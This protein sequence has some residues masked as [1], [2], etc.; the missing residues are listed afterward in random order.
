MRQLRFAR[1]ALPALLAFAALSAG[2]QTLASF[3]TVPG[4]AVDLS[5][6]NGRQPGANVNRLGGFF[7]DLSYDRFEDVFYGVADRGPGGGYISYDTRV[8][9]F[10]L[11]IDPLTGA[12]S[13][14]Q[15][16]GTI[17]FHLPAS[18]AVNGIAGPVSFNGIDPTL[19]PLNGNKQVLGRAH[20]PEGF[21]VA[22]S[23]HFYV[24]DEYGPS[25]YEFGADGTFLRAF[26]QPSNVLPYL[27][28]SI[29]FSA[30]DTVTAG[31][32]ANRGYEGLAISPDGKRLYAMLQDPLAQEGSAGV[33]CSHN[34]TQP[35]D[36]SRNLRLVEFD[37]ATGKSRAQ[38]IYQLESLSS[39][40]ER[41][42]GNTFPTYQ[43]GSSLGVSSMTMLDATHIAVDERDNRGLGVGDPLGT[44]PVS[45]KRIY[46]ID[47]AGAT[48]VSGLS[49]AGM[50]DP[51]PGIA[52]VAK[53]LYLDVAAA[54]AKAGHKVFEKME[55]IAI[56]PQLADGTYALIVGT[57]NDFSVTQNATG[58]QNDVCSDL[59]EKTSQV[60]INAGCPTGQHLIPTVYAAFKSAPGQ[61]TLPTPV[62]QLQNAVSGLNAPADLA[63]LLAFPLGLAQELSAINAPAACA[64]LGL[65]ADEV[66]LAGQ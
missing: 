41:V 21:V 25:I 5:P 42:P 35:G 2:A 49:L 10:K 29:E 46:V 51:P 16:L 60:A 11:T 32:I 26:V 40:N 13:N 53:S 52:P 36:Y 15:M 55:G 66:K 20:D 6:L 57:D 39:V 54:L 33:N 50:N 31:R 62:E 22:P 8:Q 56:G 61:V 14:L 27:G 45:T 59:Q 65:F 48:D 17:L 1:H 47:L 7:S 38:Y 64:A 44:T 37:T 30:F 58:V 23:G 28:G 24:S 19:D 4:E 12:A 3:A 34:C 63:A 18:A 9:K 43:Q